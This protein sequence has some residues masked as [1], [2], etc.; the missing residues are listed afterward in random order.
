MVKKFFLMVVIAF[1]YLS[2]AHSQDCSK[3]DYKKNQ[4]EF[5]KCLKK[6]Q[7]KK[8]NFF[9]NIKNMFP[10]N[11]EVEMTSSN[12]L[13]VDWECLNLCKQAVKGTFTISELNQFCINQCPIK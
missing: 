12:D 11:E 1:F 10:K 8:S 6:P 2:P 9:E 4:D 13:A 3:I 5:V 7:K